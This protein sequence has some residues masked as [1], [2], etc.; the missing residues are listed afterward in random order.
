MQV[1]LLMKICLAKANCCEALLHHHNTTSQLQA[2][3]NAG[4]WLSSIQLHKKVTFACSTRS[5]LCSKSL[6]GET[7]QT[8]SCPSQKGSCCA[9][10][11]TFLKEV[12]RSY[13]KPF[14]YSLHFEFSL[15]PCC[16]LIPSPFVS[17][18]QHL[19]VGTSSGV[20]YVFHEIDGTASLFLAFLL[21]SR[22]GS[23]SAQRVHVLSK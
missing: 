10:Y 12:F 2:C 9:Q 4:G 21:L 6:S 1:V 8:F 14:P 3:D 23:V 5:F 19:H 16:L 17:T 22:F 13:W 20:E 15:L 18:V 11:G 7:Y